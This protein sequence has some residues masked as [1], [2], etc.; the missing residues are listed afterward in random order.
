MPSDLTILG[1]TVSGL[2]SLAR[3]GQEKRRG[4]NDSGV[5]RGAKDYQKESYKGST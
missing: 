4:G 1:W 5:A 2:A 3:H